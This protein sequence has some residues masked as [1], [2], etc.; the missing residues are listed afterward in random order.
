MHTKA[1]LLQKA[2]RIFS[3][4]LS[5]IPFSRCKSHRGFFLRQQ[6]FEPM[7]SSQLQAA[8]KMA[9]SHSGNLKKPLVWIQGV[10]PNRKKL[11]P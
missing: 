9:D 10:L 6:T 5:T 7:T 3:T 1:T 11:A 4:E 2:R 8:A